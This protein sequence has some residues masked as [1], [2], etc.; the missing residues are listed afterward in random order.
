MAVRHPLGKVGARAKVFDF[1]LEGAYKVR[2]SVGHCYNVQEV[3]KSDR[4]VETTKLK[5]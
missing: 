3:N 1:S 4:N 2:T 5:F